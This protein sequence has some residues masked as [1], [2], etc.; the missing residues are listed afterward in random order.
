MV[1][2]FYFDGV[3]VKTGNRLL[4]TVVCIS[5]H[6]YITYQRTCHICRGTNVI[7]LLIIDVQSHLDLTVIYKYVNVASVTD[8]KLFQ[9]IEQII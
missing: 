9:F 5:L 8:N 1:F 6:C 7:V 4:V 2:D 3:T